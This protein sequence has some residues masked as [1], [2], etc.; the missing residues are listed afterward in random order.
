MRHRAALLLTLFGFAAASHAQTAFTDVSDASPDLAAPLNAWGTSW[1]DCDGDG[2][3]DLY[4]GRETDQLTTANALYRNDGGTLVRVAGAFDGAPPALGHTWGDVDNDGDLDVL[5]TGAG[6]SALFLNDGACAFTRATGTPLDGD[7]RGW[8][9]AFGDYDADGWLDVVIAHPAF[10]VGTPVQTNHLFRGTGGGALERVAEGPVVTGTAPYTVPSWSDYDLDG[11]LDL[12]IGSGPADGSLGPD[13]LYR[14][15]LRETGT[16]TFERL[17]DAP[18]A[19]DRRDGQVMNWVDMDADGDLDLLVTN[20]TGPAGQQPPHQYR[21]DGGTYTRVT[22]TPL[23]TDVSGLGLA[24]TWA[25]V[26]HDGDLDVFLTT[27]G[28]PSSTGEDRLYLN[29]GAGA[30]TRLDDGSVF[31]TRR[32]PTSGASFG[33]LDG[34]GDLDLAV[35]EQAATLG[36]RVRVW[37]NDLASARA[38]LRVRLVG[39]ASNRAGIGA[40]VWVLAGG[41]WMHREVSAQNSFNGHNALTA[42][43]GLGDASAA[44]SVRVEWPSGIVDRLAAVAGHQT[45]TVVEGQTVADAPGPGGTGLRLAVPAPNPAAGAATVRFEVPAAGPVRL[46]LLDAVGRVVAV[47]ADGARA[48]GAHTVRVDTAGLAAGLYVVRLAHAAGVVVRPLAV[49]R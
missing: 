25:D 11:D 19:T 3:D 28:P 8:A 16:A 47:L 6:G 26:D 4:A 48:A 14:N 32:A 44:D 37:R 24:N 17:T 18:L 21:N 41:R 42:H 34:D 39:T 36:P 13:Y 46:T 45:L 5:T 20:F 23:S 43:V 35:S 30:F 10:F 1:V 7:V 12:F 31:V 29:D 40:R 27:G 33:D 49:A 2:D 22:G 15:L 9:A 38:W